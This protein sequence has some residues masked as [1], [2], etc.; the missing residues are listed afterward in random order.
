M[1]HKLHVLASVDMLQLLTGVRFVKFRQDEHQYYLDAKQTSTENGV[2]VSNPA[3]VLYRIVI[4]KDYEV[5]DDVLYIPQFI[6][7]LDAKATEEEQKIRK[8]LATEISELIP[9]VMCQNMRIPFTK[10]LQV[11]D[12]MALALRKTG[13][14]IFFN[15]SFLSS[16]AFL[17]SAFTT[18][19]KGPEENC[20]KSNSFFLAGLD[21][22]LAF[23]LGWGVSLA[24]ALFFLPLYNAFSYFS[25]SEM[26]RVW[27]L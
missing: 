24:D 14:E 27:F 13:K 8:E 22:V 1:K 5:T 21:S 19:Y 18:L 2:D 20:A 10:L 25:A 9:E 11:Y 4:P 26:H 16:L 12:R 15:T 23:L 3:A 17:E 6:H 7:S